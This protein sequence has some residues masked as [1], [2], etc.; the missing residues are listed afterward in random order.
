MRASD[1][2]AFRLGLLWTAFA[3]GCAAA[4]GMPAAA[5]QAEQGLNALGPQS[6]NLVLRCTPED[7]LVLLDGM[8]QGDCRDFSGAP[9]AL[10]VPAGTHRVELQRE[11]Y[12]PEQRE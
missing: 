4:L 10:L 5:R 1:F 7:A 12:H 2:R 6:G 9:R 3:L 8:P 11:G